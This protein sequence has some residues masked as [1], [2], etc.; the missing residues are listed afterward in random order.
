MARINALWASIALAGLGSTLTL[1]RAEGDKPILHERIAPDP[2]EDTAM[3]V[4]PNSGI[5]RAATSRA[6]SAGAGLGLIDP[7][8]ATDPLRPP[9]PLESAYTTGS[10]YDQFQADRDT[11]R[12]EVSRYTEPFAPSTAPFKRLAAFDAVRDDYVLSVR[13]ARVVPMVVGGQ[14][15]PG[16]DI[17]FEDVVVDIAPEG[18]ARIPSVGPG[19]RIVRG[20][21]GVGAE[22]LGFFVSRDGADNWFVQATGVKRPQVARLV[23]QVAISRA[24]F[25]GPF[26]DV[27]WA[28]LPRIPRLPENVARDAGAVRAVI[29]VT[30]RM[31]PREAIA[32]LVEYHRGFSEGGGRLPSRGNL[33]LDLALSRQGVCRHRA[34][35]FLVTAQS[36]GIPTRMVLN[37][38]HAWVEVNDGALWRRID[39]GGAGRLADPIDERESNAFRPPRD[40][41]PWPDGAQSGDT[42][43]ADARARGTSSASAGKDNPDDGTPFGA[44]GP[45][46]NS[47]EDTPFEAGSPNDKPG[48]TP[49]DKVGTAARPPSSIALMLV[50]DVARRGFPLHVRGEVHADA[51]ACP[52]VAVE[53]WLKP[54]QTQPL[55][56][57]GTLA[58]DAGGSFA[59]GIVVP[60]RTPLGDYDVI[61]RT[62]GD[63]RCGVGAN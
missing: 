42:M 39:L 34:F 62:M 36:L 18:R 6:Q 12:P 33:Y 35:S 25:G 28:D 43:V 3:N 13:D 2:A 48:A 45:N 24:A 8:A 56:Y 21:L 50:D 61:A 9:S 20:R 63:A 23:L 1:A 41:L 10:E 52:R 54:T 29:G 58:T 14:P 44:G 51:Q 4:A 46:D 59:G 40:V 27:G 5:D 32:K 17:F 22:N 26:A 57:L 30:R 37:E 60:T 55:R 11:R 16:E 31:R 47:D 15:S 7:T 38:A 19:A 53:L 49:N